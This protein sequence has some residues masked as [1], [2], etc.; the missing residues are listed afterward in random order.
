MAQIRQP[1]APPSWADQPEPQLAASPVLETSA[2]LGDLWRILSRRRRTIAVTVAIFSALALAYCV[3]THPLYTA[4]S[5]LLIDPRDR[6]VVTN[7]LNASAVAPDGGVT[8]VESQVRVLQSNA[9]LLRAIART[10]LVADPEFGAPATGAV[11]RLSQT[12]SG[13]LLGSKERDPDALALAA[14]RRKLAVKR[15]DKVFVVDVVVTTTSADK[16]ARI[17][18]AIAE[19]YLADQADA[20]VQAARRASGE[21]RARLDSLRADVQAAESRLDTFKAENGLIASSG[22]IVS[23]QQLS[24][25]NVRLVAAQARTAEAKSRLQQVRDLRGNVLGKGSTPE[26]V[27]SVVI[28]RLRAQYA[29]LSSKEADL[30]VALGARHP[31]MLAAEA[32]RADVKRLIEAELDRIGQSSETD[33]RRALANEAT[34]DASLG[35]LRQGSIKTSRASSR[36]RELEQDAEA[37]RTVYNSFLLRSREISEQASVD[38][39]NARIIGVATPPTEPSWPLRLAIV[40]IGVVGGLSVGAGLAMAL[41]YR[42]PTLL[43]A[44]QFE[45]LLGVPV[46]GMLPRAK[47]GFDDGARLPAALVVDALRCLGGPAWPAGARSVMVTAAP[48]DDVLRGDVIDLLASVATSCGDAVLVIDAD[49][50]ASDKAQDGSTTRDGS[51]A[52]DGLIE[53]LLGRRTLAGVTAVCTE[54]GASWI[55]LGRDKAALRDAFSR[56]NVLRLLSNLGGFDLVLVDGGPLAQHLAGG[57]LARAVDQLIVAAAEGRTR[58]SDIAALG[59]MTSVIGRPIAGTL[60]VTGRAVA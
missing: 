36:M 29:E 47:G 22:R 51:Q 39:T 11:A 12:L 5:Q 10:G 1:L 40:L 21:L 8:Q 15:A 49:L 2:D 13:L 57:L 4:S 44:R 18:N 53:V 9:V 25:I 7:D 14:L 16:S 45:R 19:A 31:A 23:E 27:A 38:P 26:A 34:L 24:D 50:A 56:G 20:R 54:T 43:S 58:Q 41:E 17:A 55:G 42:R 28:E 52:Q 37:S 59:S 32:Q 35:A 60:L 33:Y 30:R 46:L 6:Q 48:T 3:V